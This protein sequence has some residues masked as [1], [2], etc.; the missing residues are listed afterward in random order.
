MNPLRQLSGTGRNDPLY[1][2]RQN[3]LRQQITIQKEMEAAAQQREAAALQGK[4]AVL[5]EIER[6]K[7]LLAG[8]G[9]V[10]RQLLAV[11]AFGTLKC[12]TNSIYVFFLLLFQG[13]RGCLQTPC[14]GIL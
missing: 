6:L 10:A 7:M 14:I 1:Q 2:A 4:E 11:R 3:D 9:T 5:A 12:P 13:L 8:G